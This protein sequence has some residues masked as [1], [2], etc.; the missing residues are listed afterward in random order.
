MSLN[1]VG[2]AWKGIDMIAQ[3]PS[4]RNRVCYPIFAAVLCL[5]LAS[6]CGTRRQQ[7][8]ISQST[9][10]TPEEA[11]QTLIRAVEG[12]DVNALTLLFGDGGRE[13][14]A[15]GD[16]VQDRNQRAAFTARIREAMKLDKDTGDENRVVILTGADEDPFAVPLVRKA[17]R[18]HFDTDEG[19]REFLA[20]RIGANELATIE[21]C[22]GYVEAQ[23]RYAVEDPAQIGIAVYAER[24]ISSP[25]K[26]DGLYWPAES[27]G[28]VSPISAQI[29]KAAAEGY[30]KPDE[31]P[32]PFHGY[33]YK[34][35]KAQGPRAPGGSRDYV[36]R[37]LML[38]GFALVA[39]P[40][41]YGAS[42][43]KTFLV[44]HDGVVLEKD[45]GDKT[46]AIAQAMIAYDPDSTWRPAR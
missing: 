28:A 36:Q 13:I 8:A 21:L 35:L 39:W 27:G 43:V 17:G 25:G 16:G 5:A 42:G 7:A 9:F 45:L 24:F 12:D 15:S 32:V 44:N 22:G 10:A 14:I 19:R 34:I 20:R 30:R 6:A 40:A 1:A 23:R 3:Q 4:S 33:Y 11:A 38:G 46:A 26:K 37:G 41:E 31:R 29:T 18:W 2:A